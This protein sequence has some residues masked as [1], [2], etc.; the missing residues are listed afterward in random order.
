MDTL[1]LLSCL[2]LDAA[3][4]EWDWQK[5]SIYSITFK[6]GNEGNPA[7]QCFRNIIF[8]AQ[9]RVIPQTNKTHI[10]ELDMCDGVPLG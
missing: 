7:V 4:N 9:K 6:N 8:L 1:R 2:N 10:L 5:A 3:T